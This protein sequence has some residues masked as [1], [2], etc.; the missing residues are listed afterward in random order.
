MPL[1]PVPSTAKVREPLVS[2]VVRCARK[3]THV[4]VLK[5]FCFARKQGLSSVFYAEIPI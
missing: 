3:G 2:F 4:L 1:S 5:Y